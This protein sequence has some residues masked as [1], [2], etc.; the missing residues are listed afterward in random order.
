[1]RGADTAA[2]DNL[3]YYYAHTYRL[4]QRLYTDAGQEFPRNPTYIRQ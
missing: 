4:I 3:L 1:M 2:V